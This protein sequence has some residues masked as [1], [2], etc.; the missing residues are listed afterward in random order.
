MLNYISEGKY[1]FLVGATGMGKT[2]IIRKAIDALKNHLGYQCHY[3]DFEAYEKERASA[4]YQAIID[5]V[6]E[7][8]I[9][10]EWGTNP[11]IKLISNLEQHVSKPTILAFDNLNAMNRE[12][13]DHFSQDCR[14]I[15]NEKRLASKSGLSDVLIIFGGFLQ[16]TY[17]DE[18]SPLWNITEQIEI[19]PIPEDERQDVIFAHFEKYEI[20]NPSYDLVERI[21]QATRGYH[22][23]IAQLVD[24]IYR[25]NLHENTPNSV[26]IEFFK[27]IWS[28][29]QP[30]EKGM[31]EE[32]KSLRKHFEVM[33]EYLETNPGILQ[34][35]LDLSEDKICTGARLPKIDDITICG[36][37]RKD[38]DGN[39]RFSNEI[40][41][42]LFLKLI[43]GYRKA[44]FC[45]F[46]TEHED[47]YERAKDIYTDLHKNGIRRP[48]NTTLAPRIKQTD[49]FITQLINR[50]RICANL[51]ELALELSDMISLVFDILKWEIFQTDI[52]GKII[53]KEDPLFRNKTSEG[54]QKISEAESADMD[55]FIQTVL[56]SMNPTI[57]W[58][59]QW[60]AIPVIISED[61]SRLFLAKFK[62]LS[63]KFRKNWN[64]ALIKF[65]H[66]ALT[67]YHY[68][69]S[70]K[71]TENR[72][73][74]LKN[75][76]EGIAREQT[77]S[78]HRERMDPLW[79]RSKEIF[80]QIGIT[81]YTIYEHIK[82]YRKYKG[83]TFLTNNYQNLTWVSK[84][85]AKDYDTIPETLK[86][87]VV[88]VSKNIDVP[89]FD[90]AH[91]AYYL[92][93]KMKSSSAIMIL[94]LHIGA[95]KFEKLRTQIETIFDLM[96]FSLDIGYNLYKN[97]NNFELYKNA[98][99]ASENYVYIVDKNKRMIFKNPKMRNWLKLSHSKG[100]L[101][102][103]PCHDQI[104]GHPEKCNNCVV[105]KVYATKETVRIVR[106]FKIQDNKDII[107]R[108][109][110]CTI[111]PIYSSYLDSSDDIIAVTVTMH[112]L[113]NY[114]ILWKALAEL[115]KK[116]DI[117]D[118]E[119]YILKTLREFGFKRVFMYKHDLTIKGHFISEDMI[120]AV[121]YKNKRLEFKSGKRKFKSEDIDLLQGHVSAWCR[122]EMPKIGTRLFLENRLEGSVE[123]K[124]KESTTK[125]WKKYQSDEKRP[126]FW[127]SMPIS[128]NDGNITKLY[129]M[130]NHGD[131]KHDREMI[132]LDKLQLLET[133]GRASGQ[134]L[135][136]ARQREYLKRFQAMLCHGTIEPLSIMRMSID[137][138]VD[139]ENI[140]ERKKLVDKTQAA[141]GMVDASLGSLMTTE[142]GPGR[143]IK[144]D[145]DIKKLLKQQTGLFKIYA[146]KAHQIK[147]SLELPSE[148]VKFITDKAVLTQI[149]NNIIGNSL[150]HF[151][152]T[153]V[154]REKRITIQLSGEN[155]NIVIK[156]SDSGEGLPEEIKQYFK[157]P[158]RKGMRH[159]LGGLG[160]G[161]S[162]EMAKMLSGR[163]EHIP[164]V[165]GTTFKLTLGRF[166]KNE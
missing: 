131:E 60:I 87:A 146:E 83:G 55:I 86:K 39:Y 67:V 88:S 77:R 95:D 33:I 22:Y 121:E 110:E 93:R 72:T 58:T 20:L 145:I 76:L 62:R 75:Q 63:K 74:L 114:Q 104:F 29:Y 89:F 64:Q 49:Y 154:Q 28:L 21:D 97:E 18:I 139:E 80:Q 14:S 61:F 96:Q 34:I 59:G 152:K 162:I 119:Q 144:E 70:K 10:I 9:T 50:L 165:K 102:N 120:G 32:D 147:F 43:K 108:T 40:Y 65:V 115:E 19:L 118:I 117:R 98:M 68:L 90:E 5:K 161:F 31:N 85:T 66:E 123:F 137:Y 125:S 126:N 109:M 37:I 81:D 140:S 36:A 107:T 160:L 69:E 82:P 129:A 6:S 94:E 149:L 128:G 8:K 51:N 78:L 1:V 134:I 3:F 41:E 44:D 46:H 27:Y 15:Y 141:L 79:N 73:L 48:P 25:K 105:D 54:I 101:E 4:F 127:V 2:T 17:K 12:F 111:F 56:T 91:K 42:K 45:L 53:R 23:L 142:R 164:T 133:F 11:S 122:K 163:L 143:I 52:Q 136:N 166:D 38:D 113:T 26:I 156:I 135:E 153:K 155:K 84:N 16:K 159:P 71:R 99:L 132:S 35:A 112:D 157:V 30:S 100:C 24:F 151:R 13:Y 130:D 92:G 124:L 116:D 47:F 150:K 138:L 57:D 106:D 103:S 148:Q 7:K 158:F